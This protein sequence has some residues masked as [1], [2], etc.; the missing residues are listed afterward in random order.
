MAKSPRLNLLVFAVVL[1]PFVSCSRDTRPLD[2]RVR[3]ALDDRLEQYDVRGVS[4]AIVMPDGTVH[5]IC[6]GFSHDSVAMQPDMLFATGSITKNLVAAL[7]L[8][9]AEE[10]ILSL[11][12]KVTK[13]LPP[14]PHIDSTI[15]LRQMLGH[16]SGIFMFWENQKLWDDLIQYRDSVFTPE[17][18]LT[19]LKQ[20]HFAP[21][22]GFRY[23]N[24]NYLLLATIITKATGSSL[25]AQLRKRF[26]QPLGFKN[27]YLSMEDAI[28][29]DQLAH[30]WG[31]N[32]EKDGQ[33]RDLT[34]LP[35]ASHESITYGSAGVFT[36]AEELA[37]WC[38]SLF[39]GRVLRRASLDEMLKFNTAASSSWC[40]SYGLGVFTFTKKIR[41]GVTA[42]GHGGGN[43]GTSAYMAYLP[44]YGVSIVVMINF[45]H[46]TCPSRM[47]EDV[48]DIVKDHVRD[49]AQR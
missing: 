2:E 23:S 33:V 11:D 3:E 41:D 18:V 49:E 17:V 25:S 21:G 44:E 4:S 29:G 34:F 40:D 1:F 12:D 47:L 45:M 24:T 7:V 27:S 39:G 26:W 43:I 6:A 8:Q 36:T 28:P 35:R 31:D 5:R 10:G 14:Y 16:T 48:I 15:T 30:V 46:G 22:K 38:S 37:V 19:Y 13:W 42:Y 9:L 20:P 32:F